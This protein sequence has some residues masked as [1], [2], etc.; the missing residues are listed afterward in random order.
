[1]IAGNPAASLCAAQPAVADRLLDRRESLDTTDLQRPG[2]R[3]NRTHGGDSHEPLHTFPKQPIVLQR[4]HQYTLGS[5]QANHCLVA[6]AQQRAQSFVNIR[7]RRQRVAGIDPA[8]W[9]LPLPSFKLS[10]MTRL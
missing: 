8:A 7:I 6:A 1:M 9:I 2:Q 10:L 4:T 5:L 3:R